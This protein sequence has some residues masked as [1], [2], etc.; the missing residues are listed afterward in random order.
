MSGSTRSYEMGRRMVEAGH[1]VHMI[2]SMR[3]S[4]VTHNKWIAEEIDGIKIHWVPIAYSNEMGYLRRIYSFLKF[5]LFAAKRAVYVGGDIIFATSTPLTIC[6]P[7]LFAKYKLS[8]PMVFEV[9]DLWP[10]LPIA[11]GAI[12]SPLIIYLTKKLE[13]FTYKHSDAVVGLSPGMCRGIVSTG[14]P[15]SKVF[16]IPNSADVELFGVNPAAGNKFRSKYEWLGTRPLVI[17]AGTLGYLNNVNYL[18]ELAQEMLKLNPDVRF[19]IVGSGGEESMIRE[20]AKKNGILGINMF[21]MPKMPKSD[22]PALFSAADICTSIFL[23]IE[24]M[25]NNSANKFFDAL[26]AGKPLAINYGGWQKK[27]IEDHKNGIVLP[28]NDVIAAAKQLNTYLKDQEEL[29]LAGKSSRNL[30]LKDFSRDVAAKR[31]LAL[32]EAT[33]RKKTA[34]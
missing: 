17:Y 4:E 20:K 27:L 21:M 7:A 24:A 3:E 2:T 12:R 26:A 15:E 22:V 18:V 6:F 13:K 28:S 23:P 31:L 30:A 19:L 10:E 9:R 1:E 34:L 11:V 25:W 32:L 33:A 14:Y 29:T 5:A 16:Y 8:V